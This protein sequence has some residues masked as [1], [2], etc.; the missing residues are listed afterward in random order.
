MQAFLIFLTYL[1]LCPGLLALFPAMM[2][3]YAAIPRKYGPQRVTY[4]VVAYP[5]LSLTLYAPQVGVS[6]LPALSLTIAVMTL[7]LYA[8]LAQSEAGLKRQ[9]N[10]FT[11]KNNNGR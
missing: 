10:H 3:L 5:L 2:I 9:A 4:P 1:V 11:E 7:L 6:V 8:V